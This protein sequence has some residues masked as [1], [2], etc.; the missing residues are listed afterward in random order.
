MIRGRF[1][2][3]SKRERTSK[4]TWKSLDRR[5]QGK[6]RRGQGYLSLGSR[7]KQEDGIENNQSSK[8]EGSREQH[9]PGGW[10]TLQS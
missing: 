4:G 9:V 5:K 2:A 10:G 7:E 8:K 3:A 6:T 1:F